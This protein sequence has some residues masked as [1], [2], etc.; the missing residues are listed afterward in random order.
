MLVAPEFA[1]PFSGITTNDY[2][3]GNLF[4][5]FG[6]RNFREEWAF[7]VVENAFDY[8]VEQNNLTN[9]VYDIFGHSAGAQFVHRV[10][11]LMPEAKIDKAIF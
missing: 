7:A 9:G 10:V 6:S 2:A 11:L 8:I 4:T 1:S 5:Y 3:D